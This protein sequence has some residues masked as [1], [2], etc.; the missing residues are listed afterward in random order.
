M[1][2]DELRALSSASELD[3]LADEWDELAAR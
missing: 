2:G 3:A 1:Q